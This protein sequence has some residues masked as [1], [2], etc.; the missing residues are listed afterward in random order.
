MGSK[1]GRYEVREAGEGGN[2]AGTFET[3]G[4]A[5]ETADELTESPGG[6]WI[7]IDLDPRPRK[8]GGK[9]R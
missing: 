6:N 2:S 7:V 1:K 5:Q 3:R 9:G 8:R 4:E